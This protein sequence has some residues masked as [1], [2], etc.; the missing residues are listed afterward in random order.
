MCGQ[1]TPTVE[2]SHHQMTMR[3]VRPMGEVRASS[4]EASWVLADVDN[5][6]ERQQEQ[7]SVDLESG[8][9]WVITWALWA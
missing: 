5:V 7:L 1:F 8:K 3:Q 6:Q 4:C 9:S 2:L